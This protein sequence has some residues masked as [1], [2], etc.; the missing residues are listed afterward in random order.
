MNRFLNYGRASVRPW[1]LAARA[2]V[3]AFAVSAAIASSLTASAGT[4]T[5]SATRM[6]G[7]HTFTQ[8]FPAPAGFGSALVGSAPVGVGPSE[9]A[10]DP[11]TQ[12]IYV[13]NGN[14]ADGPSAGGDTVSVIDARHCNA[15]DI[16]RCE[17]PWPTITVGNGT[18]TDL[19]S[20][21]AF[22]ARTDTVYVANVGASTVSVFNGATCNA[23]VISGCGQKPAEVP[24]GLQPLTLVADPANHTVYVANY[25]APGLG[26]PPGNST[27]VSM[28]DS[29]TCNATDLAGCPATPPPT[30][31]VKA[32]P[33]DVAVN[34]ATHTVYVTTI[35]THRA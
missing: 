7:S 14:N 17:G 16:S 10:F 33:D 1:A 15:Q 24:V 35:G 26:G 30:V 25:G 13:A 18:A 4:P 29:A 32:T 27:T 12:T 2:V 8:P 11:A 19:P 9:L 23:T 34:Q 31:N 6:G 22:D 3:F 5:Q 21:I 28:I 20:G